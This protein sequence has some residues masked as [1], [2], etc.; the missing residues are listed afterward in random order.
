MAAMPGP[1]VILTV[2][3]ALAAIAL[4]AAEARHAR[5][6][7]A[8]SKTVAS[9]AFVGVAVARGALAGGWPLAL[10]IG[11]ALSLVGDLLLLSRA[12]RHFLAGLAA[13]LAG[14]VAYVAAF[15]SRGVAVTGA[16][17]AAPLALIA[18]IV[19]GRWL[20]PHVRGSMR[21]PVAAYVLVIS[22]MIVVAAATVSH[23]FSVP[24][25][26]GAPAFYL[27]DLSVARDRFVAPGFVN[28]AWGLPVYY[29]AQ[30]LLAWS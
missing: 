9:A 14:H 17:V 1:A 26:L 23:R 8:I 2:V 16:A 22:T 29:A 20:A 10:L 25:A 11:L 24:L 30:F 15:A 3:G 28:R 12:R 7:K 13:F 21:G 5:A 19:V 4:V 18:L 27:S 6:A